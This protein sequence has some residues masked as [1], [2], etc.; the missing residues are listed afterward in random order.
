MTPWHTPDYQEIR[1]DAEI[2][3]YCSVLQVEPSAGA[4][5]DTAVDAC[6]ASAAEHAR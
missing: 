3:C 6:T 5:I 2:N 1:M 4:R